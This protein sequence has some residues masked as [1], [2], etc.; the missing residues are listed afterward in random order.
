MEDTVRF[1]LNGKPTK[2][3]VDVDRKL[4]WVLRTDLEL[5]GTKYWCGERHFRPLTRLSPT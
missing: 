2:L 1:K 5:T 4:L 3:T